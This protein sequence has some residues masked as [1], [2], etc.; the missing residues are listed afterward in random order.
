MPGG[1]PGKRL[2]EPGLW[3]DTVQLGGLDQAGD[4][5][6]VFTAVI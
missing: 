6:P 1:E 4:D 5:G 3:I 2:G